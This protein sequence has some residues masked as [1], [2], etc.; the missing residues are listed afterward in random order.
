V[1][2]TGLCHVPCIKPVEGRWYYEATGQWNGVFIACDA[3]ELSGLPR[4][5]VHVQSKRHVPKHLDSALAPDPLLYHLNANH[6]PQCPDVLDAQ[7]F[8]PLDCG[9]WPCTDT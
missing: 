7:M 8:R 9:T 1:R 4:C 5:H 2:T 6:L 3:A